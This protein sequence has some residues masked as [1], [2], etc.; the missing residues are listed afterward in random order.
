MNAIKT[1]MFALL[2]TFSLVTVGEVEAKKSHKSHKQSH[3]HAKHHKH[4]KSHKNS[5]KTNK[6]TSKVFQKN[7]N[8]LSKQKISP[9]AL[10]HI[11][12]RHWHNASQGANTS[13][14]SQNMTDKKLNRLA[15][16]TIKKGSERPSSHGQGRST[17]QYRFNKPIGTTTTGKKAHALRVVTDA[18]NNV[19]TAFPV[20]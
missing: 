6:K 18:N 9:S 10:S 12:D 19:I 5:S 14:F 7:K 17:H 13:H 15:T 2:M 20:K 4:A 16:K 11:K 3:S 1:T 8:N